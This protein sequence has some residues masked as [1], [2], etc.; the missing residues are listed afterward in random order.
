MGPLPR[1]RSMRVGA[2]FL[3]SPTLPNSARWRG[4]KVPRLRAARSIAGN[5]PLSPAQ[6]GA[7]E[8]LQS[9]P[10]A[11]RRASFCLSR[12]GN[13]P[14]SPAQLGAVEG[15]QSAPTARR[16]GSVRG[17]EGVQGERGQG[18]SPCPARL[19]FCHFV[20]KSD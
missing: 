13:I 5:T 1:R 6:L 11:R 14:L 8:G 17:G 20:N 19:F 2:K 15:L 18:L 16:R 3:A 9:A 4:C 7:V 12:A 10:T